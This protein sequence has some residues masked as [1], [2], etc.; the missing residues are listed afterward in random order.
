M[1]NAMFPKRPEN[2]TN[3]IRDKF[4]TN[5]YLRFVD[6]YCVYE[7]KF[8]CLLHILKSRSR[9]IRRKLES[10]KYLQFITATSSFNPR[11][12]LRSDTFHHQLRF[13]V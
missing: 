11:Q 5:I 10:V 3:G 9:R 13:P 12:R 1:V 7:T 8:H 2:L 6:M 4:N